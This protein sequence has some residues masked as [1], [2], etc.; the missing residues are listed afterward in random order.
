MEQN[1][2]K[3]H[4]QN[5]SFGWCRVL[6]L[7]N[8]EEVWFNAEYMGDNPLSSLIDVCVELKEQGGDYH[9]K[10]F[11]RFI[12]LKI[13]LSL[14]ETGMLHLDIV[15]Q[16]ETGREIY[17]EWHETIPFDTFVNA[18][19]AEGF[20]VLNAFGLYGYRR[21]WQNHTDFPLTN[22]LRLTGKC[23]EIW[24][25]C[26]DIAKEMAVLQEYISKLEIT[27]ETKMDLCTLYY[28]SWQIQ[29]CGDPFAV[30]DKV[31]W[32]CIS[33][34]AYKNAHGTIIDFEEDHHGFATHAIEG[35]VTKIIAERS[36]FPKGKREVW[37]NKAETIR[38]ELQHA[39]GWESDKRDDDTTERTFWGYIVE[40]KDVTVKPL[41]EIERSSNG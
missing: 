12:V 11:D 24:K 20:R 8:D 30:G 22:L 1:I 17:G 21:S 25:G 33:P 2:F 26:T 13:G 18:I 28:E 35:V 16:H 15:N 27:E 5:L 23:D 10:W 37:Y 41:E 7:I 36:E 31:E 34:S 19:I 9:L 14:D 4:V 39:N 29:C 32:T 38:E 40:L 3:F 6:M